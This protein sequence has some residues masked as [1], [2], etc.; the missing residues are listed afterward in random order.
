MHNFTVIRFLLEG[1]IFINAVMTKGEAEHLITDWMSGALALRDKRTIGSAA[2]PNV[3]GA[4]AWA[5]KVDAIR[6]MH[7]LNPEEW[8]IIRGQ[9]KVST[10]Q[11][12]AQAQQLG[13]M[14]SVPNFGG[15]KLSG[16]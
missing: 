1:G 11:L 2:P 9:L 10:L 6:A 4:V 15:Q 3:P 13:T 7:S 8:D 14:G 16:I 5:V 12:Q